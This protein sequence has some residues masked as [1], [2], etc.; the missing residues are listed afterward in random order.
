M[1]K[2]THWTHRLRIV[3]PRPPG[4]RPDKSLTRPPGAGVVGYSGLPIS[5]RPMGPVSSVYAAGKVVHSFANNPKNPDGS[6]PDGP[7][8]SDQATNVD[9]RVIR[10]LNLQVIFWGEAWLSAVNPSLDDVLQQV[11]YVLASPYLSELDQYGFQGISKVRTPVVLPV[12]VGSTYS[13]DDVRNL[14]WELIDQ[15]SFPEPD[16]Q[17]GDIAYF[18]FGPPGSRYDDANDRGAH[19]VAHD[20][21]LLDG[22][23]AWVGW[24]NY[25]FG[26]IQ[27]MMS[28]FTH[29]LVEM[30]SDPYTRDGEHGWLMTRKLKGDGNEIGDA[31][32]AVDYNDDGF[33]MQSYW[34]NRHNACIVPT[35]ALAVGIENPADDTQPVSTKVV[36]SGQVPQDPPLRIGYCSLDK[37]NWVKKISQWESLF[38][39][40]VHHC[41]NPDL[42]WSVNGVPVPNDPKSGTLDIPV[43][44]W[45]PALPGD[46][47]AP[48][49]PP[50]IARTVTVGYRL[51][52]RVLAIR[53]PPDDAADYWN[54]EYTVQVKMRDG[55]AVGASGQVDASSTA[56]A[57]CVKIDYPGIDDCL[58]AYLNAHMYVDQVVQVPRPGPTDGPDWIEQV[59]SPAAPNAQQAFLRQLLVHQSWG[60]LNE[61]IGNDATRRLVASQLGLRH[62]QLSPAAMRMPALGGVSKTAT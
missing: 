45:V 30:I 44:A 7:T 58:K 11:A 35:W 25:L 49:E 3:R 32:N 15:G 20:T 48:D 61:V 6:L 43:Q 13:D 12:P 50:R 29:E 38:T 55:R 1:S 37:L 42:S 16:E 2:S 51:W 28:T 36:D 59:I 33:F 56:P 34:S 4:N 21:D 39:A 18:V 5:P 60:D 62:E 41:W 24:G 31:C 22:D 8:D 19:S 23:D 40:K 17:D 57:D 14:V 9:G 52:D 10:Y 46:A 26:G 47:A 27:S 54:F 53:T